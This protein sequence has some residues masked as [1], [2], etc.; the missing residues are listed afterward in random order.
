M[1]QPEV[2]VRALGADG[3]PVGAVLPLSHLPGRAQL[4]ITA[5]LAR[6]DT[7]GEVEDHLTGVT[8]AWSVRSRDSAPAPWLS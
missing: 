1:N 5:R 8:Y 3:R 2:D 7:L 4:R 6:G